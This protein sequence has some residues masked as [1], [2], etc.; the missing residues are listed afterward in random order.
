PA[1]WQVCGKR[2]L[3]TEDDIK[4]QEF[5]QTKVVIRNEIQGPY[6][7]SIKEKIKKNEIIFKHELQILLHLCQTTCDVELARDAIYRCFGSSL[8]N[9]KTRRTF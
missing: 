4:L 3:L 9:E 7:K 5:Q 1:C 6:F 8:R 2:Y